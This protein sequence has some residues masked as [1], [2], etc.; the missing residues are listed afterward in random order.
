M[1]I[2][3]YSCDGDSEEGQNTDGDKVERTNVRYVSLEN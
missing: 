3:F 2:V 1:S